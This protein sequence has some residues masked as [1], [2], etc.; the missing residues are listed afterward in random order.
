MKKL[1]LHLT[2]LQDLLGMHRGGG[3]WLWDD[4]RWEGF[5]RDFS[6]RGLPDRKIIS[7][8]VRNLWPPHRRI[9]RSE[10]TRNSRLNS[11]FSVPNLQ[12]HIINRIDNSKIVQP[13]RRMLRSLT[14][15]IPHGEKG[16]SV[17]FFLISLLYN[18]V[19]GW[20]LRSFSISSRILKKKIN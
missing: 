15:L 6:P 7:H 13:L 9:K 14:W 3:G 20:A 8:W 5:A 10:G 16:L 11:P 19:C 2:T 18:I 1:Y 4:G 12:F 17:F